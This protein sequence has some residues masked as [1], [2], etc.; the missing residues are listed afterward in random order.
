MKMYRLG[1]VGPDSKSFSFLHGI[2]CNGC[3]TG[4]FLK[5]SPEFRVGRR[6]ETREM[7]VCLPRTEQPSPTFLDLRDH[8]L[9]TTDLELGGEGRGETNDCIPME[10]ASQPGMFLGIKVLTLWCARA[11]VLATDHQ[12]GHHRYGVRMV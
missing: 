12:P 1:Q 4:S 8:Q 2:V 5:S 7:I 9:P 3:A 11:N 6:G 10:P